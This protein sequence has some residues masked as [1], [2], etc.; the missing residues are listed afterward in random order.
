MNKK[1]K[2]NNILEKRFG[3]NSLKKFE[4]C[5]EEYLKDNG[6]VDNRKIKKLAG[7]FFK[8]GWSE[9]SEGYLLREWANEVKKRDGYQCKECGVFSLEVNGKLEAHHKKPKWKYPKLR[10][11]VSNGITLC[12]P[13]HKEADKKINE[14]LK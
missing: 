12:N 7:Y 6:F 1:M 8:L 13:C 10:F 14:K 9:K 3:K 2:I 5:W 4:K 11:I